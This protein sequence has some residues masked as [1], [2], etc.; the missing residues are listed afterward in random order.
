MGAACLLS[1]AATLLNPYGIDYL[2]SIFNTEI[3]SAHSTNY[4]KAYISVWPYLKNINFFFSNLGQTA[5]IM[6]TM[7]FFL[8]CLFLYEL[9]RKKTC[10]F[11]LLIINIALYW[12]GMETGRAS[13]FFPLAFF[14]TFFYL[15]HQLKL[16]SLSG[17]A[18]ILSLLVFFF[19]FV[20]IFYFTFGYG[21]GN[22]WFGT[23][24]DSFVPVKE[25]EF[26]KKYKLEGP[27]FNDYLIGGYLVWAL[28]PDYK[29]FIDSRGGGPFGK[30]VYPDYIEFGMKPVTS[31]AIKHFREKYPFKIAII[32]YTVLPLIFAFINTGGEWRILY[33]EKKAAI[34][35]HKSL[36]PAITP[37]MA[38]EIH[39][40][41]YFSNVSNP[42]VLLNVFNFYILMN[43]NYGRIIYD[44]YKKN[45]SDFYRPKT[46]HLLAMDNMIRQ[47]SGPNV[48]KQNL[49]LPLLP[50]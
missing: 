4:L 22:K 41:S 15:I 35:I 12:K 38:D 27:V 40:P 2:L 21:A 32:H 26:L 37:K 5:W 33:F 48:G 28:Y 13:Y 23:D 3:S 30:Q 1:L 29:V 20:N 50:E 45:V 49:N 44:I 14:F 36:F 42:E 6:T 7:L 34:L 11:S 8:G 39:S 19:F 31:E 25:V 24:L 17:R 18:T 9:I 47:I 16:K 10:D 46:M 43:P